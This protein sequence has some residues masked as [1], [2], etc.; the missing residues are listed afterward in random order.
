MIF[1]WDKGRCHYHLGLHP[2]PLDLFSRHVSK[3]IHIYINSHEIIMTS[4]RANIRRSCIAAEL[5][6]AVVIVSADTTTITA[7][8]LMARGM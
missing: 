2:P 6:I 1:L 3:N 5:S 8:H 4:R 7:Q